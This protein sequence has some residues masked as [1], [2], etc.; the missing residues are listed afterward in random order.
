MESAPKMS[1]VAGG[2]VGSRSR[3]T[4]CGRRSRPRRRSRRRTHVRHPGQPVEIDR[5]APRG[6]LSE[7]FGWVGGDVHKVVLLADVMPLSYRKIIQVSP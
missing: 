5:Q 7:E 3:R 6:G 1:V 4:L 2:G